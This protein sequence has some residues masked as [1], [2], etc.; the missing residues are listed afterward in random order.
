[1]SYDTRILEREAKVSIILNAALVSVRF[2]LLLGFVVSLYISIF[3]G[4]PKT[5]G[6]SHCTTVMVILA[7]L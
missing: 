4:G 7:K 6:E 3:H 1:M 2:R 5:N